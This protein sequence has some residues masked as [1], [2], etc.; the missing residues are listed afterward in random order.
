M[1]KH[2]LRHAL[3]KA[4][5]L[6]DLPAVAKAAEAIYRAGYELEDMGFSPLFFDTICS[7]IV[8]SGWVPK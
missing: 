3:K 2:N 8:A 1:A 7:Q 6:N 5:L 4:A